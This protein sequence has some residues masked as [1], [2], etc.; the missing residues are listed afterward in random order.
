[1]LLAPGG[2]VRCPLLAWSSPRSGRSLHLAMAATA[3]LAWLNLWWVLPLLGLTA[4]DETMPDVPGR[5]ALGD[6][7]DRRP[8][9]GGRALPRRQRHLLAARRQ[10]DRPRRRAARRGDFTR[11]RASSGWRPAARG[12]RFAASCAPAR[13]AA[14]PRLARSLRHACGTPP[15]CSSARA[16]T[17]WRRRRSCSSASATTRG[18]RQIWLRYG[19]YLVDKPATGGGDR[20]V[21]ARRRFAPRRCT[22]SSSPSRPRLIGRCPRRPRD[23]RRPGG[24]ATRAR[25]RRW[26]WSADATARPATSSSPPTSRSRRRA[27]SSGRRH[28]CAPPRRCGSAARSRRPRDCAASGSS[29]RASSS[30]RCRSTR[31]PAWPPRRPRRWSASAATRRRSSATGTPGCCARPPSSPA[32]HL[33]A[34]RG[35]GGLRRARRLGRGRRWRGRRPAST[36]R[37]G[38][39]LRARRRLRSAREEVLARR[40]P[41]WP[42]SPS[43]SPASGRVEEGFRVLFAH[44]D[45][46]GAWE[47]LSSY[48]GTFPTLAE[49]LVEA[50]RRGSRSRARSTAAIS[51]VQRATAGLPVRRELLPAVLHARR[52]ARAARRR[53]R[54]RGGLAAHRRLRLRL[55]RRRVSGCSVSRPQ[56]RRRG[57]RVRVGQAGGPVARTRRRPP[58]DPASRY[59]LEQELGPGRHGGRLPGPRQPSRPHR[60]DQDP[61][62]PPAH[63]RG[64]P[65]LRA[66]GARRGGALPP[67][68]RPHLRLRPR[69]RRRSSSRWSS[70]PARRSTSSCARSRRSSAAPADP[71]APD[72]RRRRLRPRAATSSTATSSRPT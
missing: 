62:P 56:R 35:G 21:P 52:P 14:R 57:G 40:R 28:A 53:A 37:G 64:D 58:T 66:R 11:G 54:R 25:P 29:T 6:G 20:A 51:A 46:R 13:G 70:C 3:L 45:L 39:L 9:R 68:D 1:M 24:E 72:R 26:R 30:R 5:C 8:H 63:P 36:S 18:P 23:A 38:A 47:L 22:P 43:S 2:C 42:S 48:G 65:P 17:R 15:T 19:H 31:P 16:A 4:I 44:G 41:R 61:Q 59:V 69:L 60:R 12:G 10:P 34:R 55:P 49:P 27:P 67:R 7:H 32:Q 50:R 33:D 71:H